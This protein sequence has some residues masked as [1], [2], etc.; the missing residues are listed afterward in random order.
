MTPPS[1]ERI[2]PLALP[3]S[4]PAYSTSCPHAWYPAIDI[5]TGPD[6]TVVPPSLLQLAPPLALM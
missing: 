5:Q 1:V 6:G 4:A 2:T 3:C